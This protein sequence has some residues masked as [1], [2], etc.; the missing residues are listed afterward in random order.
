MDELLKKIDM[1]VDEASVYSVGFPNSPKGEY[2]GV[3]PIQ[4]MKWWGDFRPG[5]RVDVMFDEDYISLAGT[6]AEGSFAG[7]K[8]E[9]EIE[10]PEDME[11]F[12]D[13]EGDL[14]NF[15]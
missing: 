10:T 11:M 1:F 9:M 2:K 13:A 7:V 4:F 14:W 15:V 5:D 12:K 8:K 3:R 6:N